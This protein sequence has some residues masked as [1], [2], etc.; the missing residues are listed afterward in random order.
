MTHLAILG[1]YTQPVL[2]NIQ[3]GGIGQVMAFPAIHFQVSALQ[4]EMRFAVIEFFKPARIVKIYRIV[5]FFAIDAQFALVW[6]LVTIGTAFKRNSV[7]LLKLGAIPHL[8]FMTFDAGHLLVATGE[9]KIGFVVIELFRRVELL[10][11]M[12]FGAIPAQ[13]FLVYVFVAICT[14]L[15]QSKKGFLMASK[16]RLYNQIRFVATP[17]IYFLPFAGPS[18]LMPPGKFITG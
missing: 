2:K 11:I 15:A 10:R 4:G 1:G 8:F 6:I 7:K 9:G 3:R 18:G 14:G 12:A 16:L 17:A 13:R 5:A